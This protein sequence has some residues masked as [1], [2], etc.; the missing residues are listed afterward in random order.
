[1]RYSSSSHP[2][3]TP[4]MS[5]LRDDESSDAASSSDGDQLDADQLHQPF[6]QQCLEAKGQQQH[7]Q[8]QQRRTQPADSLVA[9]QLTHTAAGL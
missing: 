1:M 3:A 4:T 2:S 7:T 6:V 8:R 9:A 5:E